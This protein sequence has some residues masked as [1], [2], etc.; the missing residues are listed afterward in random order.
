MFKRLRWL[1]TG[2]V[3]GFVVAL[4]LSRTMR[5]AA[6]RYAPER[7]SRNVAGTVKGVG[8]DVRTAMAEGRATMRQREAELRQR[9]AEPRRPGP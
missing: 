3:V 4:W 5:E 1:T 2:F 6:H 7:L 8:T 9:L